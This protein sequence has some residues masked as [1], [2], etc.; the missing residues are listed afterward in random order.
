[1][2][3]LSLVT[4]GFLAPPP[5]D[6]SVTI[7]GGAGGAGLKKEEELPRP[8]IKVLD[9]SMSEERGKVTDETFKVTAVKLVID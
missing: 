2:G 4:K 6:I 9:V 5:G 1:M 3:G 8:L 7:H